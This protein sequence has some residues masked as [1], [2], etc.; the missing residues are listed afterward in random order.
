MTDHQQKQK[1][2]IDAIEAGIQNNSFN[3]S[4]VSPIEDYENDPRTC[5]T[6]VHLPRQSLLQHIQQSLIEPLR[7]IEPNFYYYSRES[8]HTTVKNIR[9]I[10]DPPHFS[11]KD[12][13][14]AISIFAETI[15]T[16]T[17]FT[18]YFYRLLLF[19]NNLALVGTTDK[20]LDNLIL[21]LDSKLKLAGVADDKVYANTR[22]FFSNITLARF[23]TVPS[24]AFKQ[25]L[26][27]LSAALQFDPYQVDSVTLLTCNAVFKNRQI[28]GT[29]KLRN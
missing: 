3:L 22:Y 27:E 4:A 9:V 24:D 18:V 10:N 1:E 7:V 23:N 29:W 14:K 17:C 21:D 26:K 13:Q 20:K 28:K 19:P 11:E 12:I 5:L 16:H 15:P 6:S 25:K 2:I 8:L